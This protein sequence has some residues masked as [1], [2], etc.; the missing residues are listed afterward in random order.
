NGEYGF[1]DVS[2][3]VPAVLGSSG[4]KIIGEIELTDKEKELF[5][6]SVEVLKENL[7]SISS[8]NQQPQPTGVS[9]NTAL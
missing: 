4:V 5:R 3:G 2:I 9:E 1:S 6:K 8:D 7:K